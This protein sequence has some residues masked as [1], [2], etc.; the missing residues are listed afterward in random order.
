MVGA[1]QADEAIA[2]QRAL[3]ET[4]IR[5][6]ISVRSVHA[7]HHGHVDVACLEPLAQAIWRNYIAALWSLAGVDDGRPRSRTEPT[8]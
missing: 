3:Q 6:S 4:R 7:R 8:G 5:C 1:H 2:K